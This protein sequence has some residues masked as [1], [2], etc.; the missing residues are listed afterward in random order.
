MTLNSLERERLDKQLSPFNKWDIIA[1]IKWDLIWIFENVAYHGWSP[2]CDPLWNYIF[3]DFSQA[4]SKQWRENWYVF[5]NWCWD[6]DEYIDRRKYDLS[7]NYKLATQEQ[8]ELFKTL[9]N[10]EDKKIEKKER[11]KKKRKKDKRKNK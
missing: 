9:M 3:A 1:N 10:Q 4:I 6:D 5:K 8:I 7:A 2:D 11:Q